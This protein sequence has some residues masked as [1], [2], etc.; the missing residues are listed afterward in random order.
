MNESVG[1]GSFRDEP[2]SPMK[3][4]KKLA[5]AQSETGEPKVN[6]LVDEHQQQSEIPS[7]SVRRLSQSQSQEEEFK[8]GLP[9]TNT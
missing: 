8:S 4:G 7:P 2:Q 5:G 6:N 3:S 1:D 9:M